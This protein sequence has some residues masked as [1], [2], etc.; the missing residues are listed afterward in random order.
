MDGIQEYQLERIK[1]ATVERVSNH[2]LGVSA[3]FSEL[4]S[5]VSNSVDMH[6]RGYIWGERGKSE[7]IKYPKNWREAFK[8][9]WF[10]AWL[11]RR[12]PVVYRVHE[13]NTTT[14]YPN[15]KISVPDQTHVLKFQTL[16]REVKLGI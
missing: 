3:S 6:V 15:F 7:T 8:E 2:L 10:P 14:L 16:A 5:F 1:I 12:Y 9:R 4:E 13:I 11:L